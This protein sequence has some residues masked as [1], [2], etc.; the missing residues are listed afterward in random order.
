MK[1]RQG[2]HATGKTG[3]MA[4]KKS[5]SGKTQGIWKFSESKGERCFDICCIPFFRRSWIRQFCVCNSHKSRKLAQG[6][7]MVK[8]GKHREFENAIWVGTPYRV[9]HTL[10]ER[11]WLARITRNCCSEQIVSKTG[12]FFGF[13]FGFYTGI[14]QLSWAGPPLTSCL[15]HCVTFCWGVYPISIFIA[16]A[17]TRTD[18]VAI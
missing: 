18:S 14:V 2:T 11:D 5:L 4:K 10:Q 3:K 9:C 1:Y 12:V 15:D 16:M 7:F 13:F 6:K 17:G 8:Q